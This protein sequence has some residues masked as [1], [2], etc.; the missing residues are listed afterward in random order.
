MLDAFGLLL[1]LTQPRPIAPMQLRGGCPLTIA[2]AIRGIVDDGCAGAPAGTPQYPSLLA[3]YGSARPP[4]DVPGVDYYVGVPINKKLA[5]PTVPGKLPACATYQASNTRVVV[6]ASGCT[7]NG[8]DF[9]KAGGLQVS[10]PNG[11]ANTVVENS[12]FG[13]SG[14]PGFS[15]SLLDYRGEGLLVKN[16]TFEGVG[17][18]PMYFED[19]SSGTVRFEYNFFYDISGDALDFGSSQTVIVEFNAFV[20]IGMN[21]E[22]HPDAVQFCGGNIDKRSHESHNLIYQPVGVASTGAQGIQVAVQCGGTIDG[23]SADHNTVI[24]PDP[25][26]LTMSYSVASNGEN[27]KLSANYID[28]S[29]A[30]GPIYPFPQGDGSAK[31][32]GNVA[33]TAGSEYVNGQ[34][35]YWAAGADIAGNFGELTCT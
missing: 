5:D 3:S 15:T 8:F 32:T 26:S 16:S 19:G 12:L 11:V 6:T 35:Y 27:V 33:L 20:Q 29:G 7:L 22:S 30:Y 28:A 4:F 1:A 25:Q 34:T 10:I 23:Y 14:N 24:A 21:A 31:C 2:A 18:D 13:L 9:T 17:Q